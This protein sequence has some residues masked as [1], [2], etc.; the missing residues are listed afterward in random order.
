MM[1]S[2]KP[3]TSQYDLVAKLKN[4]ASAVKDKSSVYGAHPKGRRSIGRKRNF[5]VN[6]LGRFPTQITSKT[7]TKGPSSTT[8]QE[9]MYALRTLIAHIDHRWVLLK[10][11]TA[12]HVSCVVK[13]YHTM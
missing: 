6:A 1:Y 7:S 2:S 5:P 10:A 13:K 3:W 9:T 11:R 4:D 8:A 12:Q